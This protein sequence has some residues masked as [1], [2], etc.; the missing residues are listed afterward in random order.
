MTPDERRHWEAME[1]ELNRYKHLCGA[2]DTIIAGMQM[3]NEQLV[4]IGDHIGDHL[5]KQIRT[6][7]HQLELVTEEREDLALRSGRI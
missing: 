6:L 5:S 3:A 7:E 2:K 1:L 4:E